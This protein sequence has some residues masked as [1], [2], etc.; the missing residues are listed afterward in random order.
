MK[1]FFTPVWL[2]LSGGLKIWEC[3]LDLL[4][5]L[6]KESFNFDGLDVLD[7]GC[8]SGL[9]GIY[10]L[11]HGARHVHFQD[12]VSISKLTIDISFQLLL[13][14]RMQ[15]QFGSCIHYLKL[16]FLLECRS[17]GISDNTQCAFEY[18]WNTTIKAETFW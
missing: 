8:G 7:L 4:S 18:W 14:F 5:F 3:T 15:H 10:A 13:C 17:S 16:F 2:I 6:A 11:C 12:Y 9:L 1:V